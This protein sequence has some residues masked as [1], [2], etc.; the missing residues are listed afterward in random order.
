MKSYSA[1]D[2]LRVAKRVNN[3]RRPYLLVNPLQ[4]KHMPVSPTKS[5]QM[6]RS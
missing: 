6:I 2:V 1:S 4:G 3:P 5:L